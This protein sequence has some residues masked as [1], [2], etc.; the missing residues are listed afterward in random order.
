MQVFA[1]SCHKTQVLSQANNRQSPYK[2]AVIR[3]WYRGENVQAESLALDRIRVKVSI[4]AARCFSSSG[5]PETFMMRK[6]PFIE[7]LDE[8]I[9]KGQEGSPAP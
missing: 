1:A 7:P 5:S 2:R 6:Q 9:N 3:R 8:V 4:P